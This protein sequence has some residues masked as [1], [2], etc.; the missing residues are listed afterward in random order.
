MSDIKNDA[1]KKSVQDLMKLTGR[2]K[3]T[4]YKLAGKLGR[5]PTVEEV[6]NRKN[7]R[8]KKYQ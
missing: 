8:P 1:P 6:M 4:I 2:S 3:T 7:G 5:L